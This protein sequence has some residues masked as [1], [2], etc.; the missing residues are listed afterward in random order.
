MYGQA[1][2]IK[3]FIHTVAEKNIVFMVSANANA[4]YVC[5]VD[6]VTCKSVIYLFF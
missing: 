3:W 1:F 2:K 4:F 5:C 6:S